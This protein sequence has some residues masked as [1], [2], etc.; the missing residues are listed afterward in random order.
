MKKENL[1]LKIQWVPPKR[2]IYKGA[3]FTSIQFCDGVNLPRIF[4]ST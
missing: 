1:F 2:N 4:M 3:D